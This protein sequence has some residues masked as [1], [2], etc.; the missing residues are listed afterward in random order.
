MGFDIAELVM[1]IEETFECTIPDSPAKPLVTMADI[2]DLVL[3]HKSN[4]VDDAQVWPKL[5][6]LVSRFTKVPAEK[7]RPESRLVE[8]L[9]LD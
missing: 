5:V 4:K 6:E 2:S 1:D 3:I 9:G 8:D 7:I